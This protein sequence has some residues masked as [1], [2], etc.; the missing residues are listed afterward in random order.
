[1][2]TVKLGKRSIDALSV[3]RGDRVFW[4]SDL[5]GFGIRVHA[6]GRKIFVAQARTP[7]GLPK[8]ARIGRFV[9][10]TAEVAR[11]KAAEIIDR[12][13]R[14]EDPVPSPEPSEPTVA[15]LAARYMAAHV[16]VNCR[17]LTVKKY[18][19][20]LRLHIL[21]ELGGLRLSEADRSHVSALHYKLRD[22]PVQANEAVGVVSKMFKLAVAWGMTPAAPNPCRSVKRYRERSC[23]R[24]L[25]E[26]EYARL[27]RV[28]LEAESEG[29]RMASAVAAIRLLLLTGCRRDEILTLRWE[30]I[31]RVAGE[32]RLR[33]SKSGPRRL[34]LTPAVERVLA[35]IARTEGNPWVIIGRERGERLQRI[36][37]F[38]NTLRARAGLQDVR[39]HDL[40]HSFAS[41]A[42]A[43]GE[44]LPVIARLLGHKTVMTTYRYAHLAQDT[45][46]ASAAKV[47]DSIGS[48]LLSRN[49]DGDK[50]EAA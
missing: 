4:D 35:R 11:R 26:E 44:G 24:F 42:L 14:G 2:A 31:D 43:L 33:D 18:E 32:L 39:L 6:T 30:D 7:G 47:G 15:D 40:R 16:K 46:K 23:E 21:P 41:Q 45:E 50:A 25:S 37:P 12:I 1:M 38:W 48:D 34:P 27:G 49:V 36:D 19:G 17:P 3:E 13:R 5:P 10:M 29:L 9:D 22:K 8:R 28:L 20:L